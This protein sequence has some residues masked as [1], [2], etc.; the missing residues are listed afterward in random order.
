M[1]S[2]KV[3]L[4]A[5]VCALTACSDEICE[6]ACDSSFIIQ[7]SDGSGTPLAGFSGSITIDDEASDLT[8]PT[9]GVASVTD[10]FGRVIRFECNRTQLLGTISP[11][12][13]RPSELTIALDV[14]A[15]GGSAEFDGDVVVAFDQKEEVCDRE[16][17]NGTADVLLVTPSP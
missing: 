8:C 17:Y 10:Q 5:I 6:I 11:T 2:G 15:T 16:C 9:A 4:G 1:R 12:L 3:V 13:S 7:L 14:R